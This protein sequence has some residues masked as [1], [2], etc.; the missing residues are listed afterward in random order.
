MPARV[1]GI[2]HSRDSAIRR[3]SAHAAMADRRPTPNLHL[4]G[5]RR[6]L[7]LITVLDRDGRR[8]CRVGGHS[9]DLPDLDTG[10]VVLAA[11]RS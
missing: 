2:G 1:A 11:R 5:R 9:E 6:L 8:A 4:P 3:P 10:A 7:G